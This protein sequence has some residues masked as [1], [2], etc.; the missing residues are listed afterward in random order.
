MLTRQT[1]DN[2]RIEAM[3]FFLVVPKYALASKQNNTKE[4]NVRVFLCV[5]SFLNIDQNVIPYLFCSCVNSGII[6][7]NFTT[8]L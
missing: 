3:P 2:D 8:L 1:E 4:Q 5:F 7:H 6:T